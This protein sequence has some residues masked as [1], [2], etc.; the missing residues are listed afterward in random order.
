MEVTLGSA[1]AYTIGFSV[2]YYL[3]LSLYVRRLVRVEPRKLALYVAVFCVFGVSGEILV[4][5]VWKIVFDEQLWQ[6]QLFPA[7]SG[8]ISYF[9]FFI[10]GGLGYYRYLNDVAIHNF[11]S[12]EY[13]RPGLIMGA[14]AVVLELAY[15]GLFYLIFGSYVFYYLPAN[16]G[17]LSHL[18]CFEVIP[19][20]FLVGVFTSRLLAIERVSSRYDFLALLAFYAM[21]T[22]TLVFFK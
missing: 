5:N 1:L 22:I 21:V 4:N 2:L 11:K 9:F 19:F 8:D 6:Y 12:N 7:H 10:W 17:P 18:S 15:N 14:E 20:Y 3:G 16:L 13:L